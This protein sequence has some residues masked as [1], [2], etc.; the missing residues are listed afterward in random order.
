MKNICIIGGTSGIG[1][2]LTQKVKATG[3]QVIVLSRQS[4]PEIEEL[5]VKHIPWDVS[6][7]LDQQIA[8]LPSELHGL[9]YCPGTINLKPFQRL[10]EEEFLE[11]FQINVMGAIRILQACMKPLRKAK[12]ASVVL[13][14]TV[15]AKLGMNFHSSIAVAKSGVEGLT[16]SLAAEWAAHQVRVNAIAPSLTDTPLAS[17]LLSSLDK[18]EAASKRHPMQKIGSSQDIADL[19]YFLLSDEANWL[20]GQIIGLDG[21]M[22]NLKP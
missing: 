10:S 12:G 4:R 7:A 19:A 15:A 5:N 21:G 14:S 18:R 9:V 2:A 1:L 17:K 16:K 8:E 13:F 3:H 20:T 22:A 6:Q 11:D